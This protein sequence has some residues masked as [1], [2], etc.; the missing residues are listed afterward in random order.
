MNTFTQSPSSTQIIAYVVVLMGVLVFYSCITPNFN[1]HTANITLS[2][3][4]GVATILLV[5]F[6]FLSSYDDPS[7]PTIKY[8]HLS[9]E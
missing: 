8:Y 5:L 4:Y 2:V 7:D 3:L 6:A 1:N 9:I